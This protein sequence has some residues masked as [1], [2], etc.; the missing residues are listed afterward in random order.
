MAIDIVAPIPITENTRDNEQK[1]F[2]ENLNGKVVVRVEDEAAQGFFT[3]SL[4]QGVVFDYGSV[5][6]PSSTTEVYT[7]R[8]GGVSGPV[9]AI[10][11]I[12]Y[13]SASKQNLSTFEVVKP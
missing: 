3:G 9:V 7:Y 11:T 1:K 5:A 12:I 13:T 2:A 4:L 10:I 8:N 6:Y